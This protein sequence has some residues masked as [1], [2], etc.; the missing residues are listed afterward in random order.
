[1]LKREQDRAR[2]VRTAFENDPTYRGKEEGFLARLEGLD[3][4]SQHFHVKF[5]VVIF[6]IGLF[7]I[8]LAAV[9]AKIATFIP[10]SYTT[11]LAWHDLKGTVWWAKELEKEL[12]KIHKDDDEEPPEGAPA[13][14]SPRP[15]AKP[16]KDTTKPVP[17]DAEDIGEALRQMFPQSEA[18]EEDGKPPHN[19]TALRKR[20]GRPTGKRW[21]PWLKKGNGEDR[22]QPRTNRSSAN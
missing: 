12:N 17:V 9:L 4:I 1:L 22:D 6:H 14:P 10:S 19:D 2:T 7:G 13:A 8:E 21:K 20:K 15:R 18:L 5:V 3:R 11:I 16:E